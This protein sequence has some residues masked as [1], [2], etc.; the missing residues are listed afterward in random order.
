MNAGDAPPSAEE[1][2]QTLAQRPFWYSQL[3]A[4][5]AQ[6]RWPLGPTNWAVAP[7]AKRAMVRR[8]G[9]CILAEVVLSWGFW[10][11]GCVKDVVVGVGG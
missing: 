7:K 11:L 5:P 2:A 10:W 3:M 6:K 8:V 1:S 4:P 9:N